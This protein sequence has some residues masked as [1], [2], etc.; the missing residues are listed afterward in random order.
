MAVRWSPEETRLLVDTLTGVEKPSKTNWD[1][2][3]AEKFPTRTGYAV[4]RAAIKMGL[5]TPKRASTSNIGTQ[6]K[7]ARLEYEELAAKPGEDEKF[8]AAMAA[9]IAA[10]TERAE[11]GVVRTA[12]TTAPRPMRGEPL[13]YIRSNAALALEIGE[14]EKSVD[15]LTFA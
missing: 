13:I 11:F 8:Q 4:H 7:T 12:C 2:L 14:P 6:L 15:E 5:L 3:A 9:A 1:A 10:G